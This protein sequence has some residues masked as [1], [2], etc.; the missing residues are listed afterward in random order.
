M[1]KLK[2]N[3]VINAID[4]AKGLLDR[5]EDDAREV[6]YPL[7]SEIREAIMTLECLA[8]KCR[9]IRIKEYE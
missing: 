1:S 4:K 7:G 9:N 6:H 3:I 8:R 5:A 2:C